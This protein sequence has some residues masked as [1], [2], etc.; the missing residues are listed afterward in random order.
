MKLD[1]EEYEM[2]LLNDGHW[3]M[4]NCMTLKNTLLSVFAASREW[5]IGRKILTGI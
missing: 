1:F 5:L 3:L 4:K 2:F